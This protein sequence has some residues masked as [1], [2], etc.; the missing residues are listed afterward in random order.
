MSK[1][2]LF[3]LF[4]ALFLL[5]LLWRIVSLIFGGSGNTRQSGGQLPVAVE[6][7][8]VRYEAIEEVRE[9]TGSVYPIYQYILAPKVSGRLLTIRKRIGDWVQTGEVIAVLDD[10][11]YQQD[12]REAEANL[13]IAESSLIEAESQALL[14]AQELERVRLLK[15]KGIAAQAE[16]DV[17]NSNHIARKSRLELARAQIEQRQAALKSAQI[18]LDYT[19][20][21]ANQPGF[22]GERYVDEGALL[23]VNAAVVSV[24]GIDRVIVRTTIV[25]RDYGRIRV[26]QAANVLVDAYPGKGLAGL[27][28]RIAPVLDEA[29]RVAKM[30]VEVENGER[31]LKPG[32]FA[33]VMVTLSSSANAQ[34][35][36]SKAVIGRNGASALF[37]VSAD[38]KS[39]RHVPV[40]IGIVSGERTEI[41]SPKLDGRVITLGQHLLQDGSLILLSQRGEDADKVSSAQQ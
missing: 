32:M 8:L 33:R 11:E 29:S 41:I 23:S 4:A 19:R 22:I 37:L 16:F 18:R 13:K 21:T 3:I 17:A 35:V 24:V 31:I 25:E 28:A 30:E 34:T 1:R 36:P 39:A 5:F 9:F 12:L 40:Q 6:T 20:L 26:G 7:D 10:A 27:V 15:E 2:R 38:G 14:A